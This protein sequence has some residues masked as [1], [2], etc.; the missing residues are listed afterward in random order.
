MCSGSL[1]GSFDVVTAT[2]C[3]PR[4]MVNDFAVF[5]VE[6]PRYQE[7]AVMLLA[8]RRPVCAIAQLANYGDRGVAG[9][10]DT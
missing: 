5:G 10:D 6:P 9:G 8:S 2:E 4:F 3:Q 1:Q 7:Q